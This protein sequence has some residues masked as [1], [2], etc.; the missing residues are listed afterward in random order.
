MEKAKY[1]INI[2]IVALLIAT[3]A[4]QRDG[5]I[6]GKDVSTILNPQSD[7]E[8][9]VPFETKLAD[10]TVILNTTS[11]AKDIIGFGGR[12]PIEI[13]LKN[14]KI[15]RV[16][17]LANNE[18]P[19]FYDQV[20]RSGLFEEFEGLT[21]S[22]AAS[23]KFDA[24]SGATYTSQAIIDNLHRAAQLGAGEEAR[25]EPLISDFKI[26]DFVGLIVILL[27]VAMTLAGVRNRVFMTIQLILNVVVLGF[28]CGSFLSLTTLTAWMSNGVN[29]SLSIVTF[30]MLIVT[31]LMPFYGR[32][33]SYCQMHCPM[34]SAQELLGLVPLTKLRIA[35]N[36]ARVLN[37]LRYYI[38]SLLLF[39]MWLGVGFEL[40]DYEIF[41]AFIFNSASSVVLV[42]AAVFLV[43]SLFI[44][45]PYCRFVCP[46]GALITI[47]QKTK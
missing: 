24:V 10:G 19:S 27:G 44:H 38:L 43:L 6:T 40:M 14:G 36:I 30:T 4:I 41:S 22:E 9:V 33:G 7:E 25:N 32:K 34:G 42:M 21:L 39:A 11:V 46:T 37:R 3:V 47:S 35:P 18:T 5:T 15:E 29:L 1:I 31:L 16:E 8:V 17:Q 26:K 28:W 13:Y 45:R 12:T 2:L 23:T 20:L